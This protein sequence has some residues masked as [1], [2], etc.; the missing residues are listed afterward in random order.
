MPARDPFDDIEAFYEPYRKAVYTCDMAAIDTMFEY[1]YM[2]SDADG[3]R[4]IPNSDLYR[5]ACAYFKSIGAAG[6]NFDSFRKLRMGRDGAMVMLR[7]TRV[8]TDGSVLKKGRATYFLRHR[9]DGWKFVG[10]IDEFGD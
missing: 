3:I 6:S 5:Q 8:H 7:Y 10:I 4:E 9:P 1:P 2:I